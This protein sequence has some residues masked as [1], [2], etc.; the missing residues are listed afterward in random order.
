M[1]DDVDEDV[2]KDVSC[3]KNK[4]PKTL[5]IISLVL[6]FIFII[7]TILYSV[8]FTPESFHTISIVN[9]CEY[10]INILFGGQKTADENELVYLPTYTLASQTTKNYN[11]TPGA[12]I[13]VQGYKVG[14][15]SFIGSNAFTTV[16][17][18]LAN[19]D[20]NKNPKIKDGNNTIENLYAYTNIENDYDYYSVSI[21]DGFNIPLT[22]YPT[23]N[24]DQANDNY[25]SGPTWINKLVCPNDLKGPTGT[26]Y[27]YCQ[28]P[29]FAELTGLVGQDFCCSLLGACDI[30]DKCEESWSIYYQAFASA[31]PHCLI[32]N[33]DRDN[34]YCKSTNNLSN[35]T[36]TFCPNLK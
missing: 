22:I 12:I 26:N 30:P 27:Q 21:Q 29:C 7:I 5:Y 31:C 4:S 17:L 16:N 3:P 13:K 35:Y 10:P 28:T 11:A 23:S 20:V 6:L 33:C 34:F 14:N 1:Y 2:D 32:T 15:I 18:K 19:D 9:N 36:L 25:C 8:F 24:V